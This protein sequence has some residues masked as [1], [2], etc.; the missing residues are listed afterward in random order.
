MRE[1]EPDSLFDRAQTDH[2]K[3]FDGC[4]HAWEVL[5][6]LKDYIRGIIRPELRNKC[7]GA[8]FIGKDVFIDEGS[9]VEDG[10]FILGPAYIGKRVIIRHGAYIRENVIVGDGCVIGNSCEL[11]NCLL[12]NDVQVPHFN[13][14]GDSV[15]GYRVHLGAGVIL[16]NL[17]SL[18]GTVKVKFEGGEIDTGLRKFGALIG[19][20]A[21]I[22]CNAVLNPGSVLGKGTIVYPCVSWRGY[23]PPGKIA[24]L[25]QQ[26]S[27]EGIRE[28]A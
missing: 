15:L 3:V 2:W 16:S 14:V 10:A 28:G 1:F 20:G 21:E 19:D 6:I 25:K 26:L 13:Y 12:F 23:L 8:A 17:R 24:K 11:K 22:G 4:N 9:V 7:L 27:V 5:P 18:E